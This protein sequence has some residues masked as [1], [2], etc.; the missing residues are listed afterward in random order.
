MNRPKSVATL[1]VS[2]LIL[3]LIPLDS[4]ADS[5]QSTWTQHGFDLS[6]TA[7]NSFETEIR[8]STVGRLKLKWTF[9][10]DE[11]VPTT[12][13]VVDGIVYVGTW[14]GI[15]YALDTKTGREIWRFNARALAGDES[16]WKE[17]GIGIRGGITVAG[18][19]VYFGDTA[20]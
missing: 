19:R 6:N 18:G 2:L 14:E 10:V 13:A 1:V 15:L 8:A 20:G 4:A 17:R 16:A 7:Y 11:M 5:S 12:P 9:P 3:R